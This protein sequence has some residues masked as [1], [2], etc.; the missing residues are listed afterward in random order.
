MVPDDVVLALGDAAF[1]SS[2]D[3]FLSIWSRVCFA[4]I[5]GLQVPLRPAAPPF[6]V[7]VFYVFVADVWETELLVAVDLVGLHFWVTGRLCVGMAR[8]VLSLP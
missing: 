8:V 2:V 3:D 5:L 1:R 6:L 4:L 7:E